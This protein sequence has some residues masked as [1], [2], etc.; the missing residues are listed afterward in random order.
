MTDTDN[1]FMNIDIFGSWFE[2]GM[3]LAVVVV[4]SIM[5]YPI[6]SA[7]IDRRKR[8]KVLPAS[9]SEYRSVHTRVHEI[10]TEIRVKLGADRALV[11]Q[12]HNGGQFM[13]GT[14]MRKM[15]TTHESCQLGVSDT[16]DNRK[17]MVLSPFVE[18]LALVSNADP[19]INATSDMQDCHFKRHLESN[20]TLVYSIYPIKAIKGGL[21]TISG[22]ILVEWCNWDRVD[23]IDDDKVIVE[24]PE[25]VRYIEGQLLNNLG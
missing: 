15:S 8:K 12:F 16:L 11:L 4:G 6:V 19:T 21:G 9:S 14:C 24:I 20:H 2:I 18:M 3:V 5:T 10:L 17:D 13:D 7:L 23:M 1:N 25:A 22:A